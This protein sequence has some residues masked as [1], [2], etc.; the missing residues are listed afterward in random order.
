MTNEFR[1]RIMRFSNSHDINAGTIGGHTIKE[2]LIVDDDKSDYAEYCKKS[3]EIG[4]IPA[5]KQ[6]KD[7]RYFGHLFSE[8]KS[9]NSN[10]C[11]YLNDLILPQDGSESYI[12]HY[13]NGLVKG[14]IDDKSLRC[15]CGEDFDTLNTDGVYAEVV[16]SRLADAVGVKTVY[17]LPVINYPCYRAMMSVDYVK[18][19]EEICTLENYHHWLSMYDLI[20]HDCV[21]N[22]LQT[23]LLEVCRDHHIP[24]EKQLGM[25]KD[26]IRDFMHQVLF[27]WILCG[28][29]DIEPRNFGLII[30]EG[31]YIKACP[32]MD[33]ELL[34]KY[35]EFD[36]AG[37]WFY[38]VR[39][40]LD[41]EPQL[42]TNF[43]SK[44]L[45]LRDSGRLKEIM[46]N[47]IDLHP[48]VCEKF[49]KRIH[50]RI[51]AVEKVWNIV[52]EMRGMDENTK[53]V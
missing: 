4:K 6:I 14:Y 53:E 8:L 39:Y 11:T 23:K 30:S 31:N 15:I 37:D 25:V 29:D 21:S 16:G 40:L 1:N 13:V 26:I 12:P 5:V 46:E 19:G 45:E 18:S 17:N 50:E 24:E 47:S 28:D 34:F 36:F 3:E 44:V 49:S 41:T 32:C 20:I 38:S 10:Y 42:V 2:F 33:M 22:G 35:D 7:S 51:K 52:L 9:G 48:T 27:K 43:M